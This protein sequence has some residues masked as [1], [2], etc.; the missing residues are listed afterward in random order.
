M[1]VKIRQLFKYSS[2]LFVAFGLSHRFA[3]ETPNPSNC[4]SSLWMGTIS[5]ILVCSIIILLHFRH[6]L[7]SNTGALS[8][9][10]DAFQLLSPIVCHAILIGESLFATEI[11]QRM[12]FLVTDT[13]RVIAES[14]VDASAVDNSLIHL[15][16]TK[17]FLSQLIPSCVECFITLSIG[18]AEEWQRHWIARTFS[19]NATRLAALH[20][21]LWVDYLASRGHLLCAEL[22]SLDERMRRRRIG[23]MR[24]VNVSLPKSNR[25]LVERL[26]R[27]KSIHRNMWRLCQL[28][29]DRFELFILSTIA[30]LFLSI[31]IDLYWIYGNFRF[32]G[33]PF[34]LREY[35]RELI[36]GGRDELI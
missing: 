33:N 26:S 30:N 34:A 13:E 32:G 8:T 6:N 16:W 28:V 29:N 1:S 35:R 19:F 2:K 18:K 20:F 9:S 25:F 4:R 5:I 15:Y 24:M 23:R 11:K 3:N 7:L 21:I 31:T 36:G 22:K 10:I 12:W 14:Q 17:F 27:L